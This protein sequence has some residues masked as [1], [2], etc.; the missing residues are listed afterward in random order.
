MKYTWAT[1]TFY[2]FRIWIILNSPDL[3]LA[4]SPCTCYIALF[5]L[6]SLFIVAWLKTIEPK[7]MKI[8][9]FETLK[10]GAGSQQCFYSPNSF[11][12][13]TVARG[14]TSLPVWQRCSNLRSHHLLPCLIIDRR[15]HIRAA[16][17][18]WVTLQSWLSVAQMNHSVLV[19]LR[20]RTMKSMWNQDKAAC[21][22]RERVFSL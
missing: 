12:I 3:P 14:G 20:W 9:F 4:S 17:T 22:D 18:H 1:E 19:N 11:H 5:A 13:L 7:E 10:R 2:Y 6:S 21:R 8:C 15:A 16:A